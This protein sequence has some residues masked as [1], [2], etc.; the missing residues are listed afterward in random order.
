MSN[1]FKLI[2]VAFAMITISSSSCKKDQLKPECESGDALTYDADMKSLIDSKCATS[3]CHGSGSGNGDFSSYS[4]LVSVINN[5]RLEREVLTD[6][7][8]PRGSSNLS[9]EEINSFQCWAEN[10][11]AEN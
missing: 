3:G 2:F 11:F 7:T 1:N 8:M 10:E 4:G 9:Q 6:Q 5:G